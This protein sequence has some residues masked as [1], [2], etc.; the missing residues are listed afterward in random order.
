MLLNL[1]HSLGLFHIKTF[2]LQDNVVG[3]GICHLVLELKEH[4]EELTSK[5]REVLLLE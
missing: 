2:A 3:E 1:A 4:F 5:N